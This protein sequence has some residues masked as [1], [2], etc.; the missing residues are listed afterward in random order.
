MFTY[1]CLCLCI[2]LPLTVSGTQLLLLINRICQRQCYVTLMIRLHYWPRRWGA[3]A[4][5]TFCLPK[6]QKMFDKNWKHYVLQI[7][8]LRVLFLVP[9]SIYSVFLIH[10]SFNMLQNRFNFPVHLQ[11]V[12]IYSEKLRYF[13]WYFCVYSFSTH[14]TSFL[15]REDN[16]TDPCFK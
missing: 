4:L 11:F 3:T 8:N 5:N 1:W 16:W 6:R 15:C 10:D 14:L 12:T 13:I 9:V 7:N 2:L